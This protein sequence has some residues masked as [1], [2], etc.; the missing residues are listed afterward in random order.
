MVRRTPE[1]AQQT[2]GRILDSAEQVFLDHGVGAATL[3]QIADAAGVTRGAVYH[4]FQDKREILDE[5][6][7]RVIL[8][9][10]VNMDNTLGAPD[11]PE[12]LQRLIDHLDLVFRYLVHTPRARR[13]FDILTTRFE[14]GAANEPMRQRKLASRDEFRTHLQAALAAAQRRGELAPEPPAADLALG[15][16]ALVDGF[17]R[18]WILQPE[19]FDLERVGSAAVRQYLAGLR[20]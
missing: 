8:P 11:A 6:L 5:M 7:A 1:E 15:L 17:I 20:R 12:P 13:V 19:L 2:R 10:Q 18:T 3:Q 4:H 9:L 16:F 14:F